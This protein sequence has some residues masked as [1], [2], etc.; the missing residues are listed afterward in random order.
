MPEVDEMGLAQ[1]VI[2]GNFLITFYASRISEIENNHGLNG[3]V[4]LG[5]EMKSDFILWLLPLATLQIWSFKDKIA[6][7]IADSEGSRWKSK[8]CRSRT[9][10]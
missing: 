8:H 1:R 5:E 7:K 9:L 10:V 3:Q 2:P 6:N 4:W